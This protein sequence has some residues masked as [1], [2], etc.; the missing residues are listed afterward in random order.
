MVHWPLCPTSEQSQCQSLAWSGKL[1]E[2]MHALVHVDLRLKIAHVTRAILQVLC[3][4]WVQR[5]RH[6]DRHTS[7]IAFRQADQSKSSSIRISSSTGHHDQWLPKQELYYCWLD[8][9]NLLMKSILAWCFCRSCEFVILSL[10]TQWL[11]LL[12]E[13]SSPP[14]IPALTACIIMLPCN[15]FSLKIV[16]C[17]L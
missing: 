12:R 15:I 11:V 5:S 3:E 13:W 6:K 4:D 14:S 7:M 2:A 10:D 1:D 17:R 8:R 9:L 16:K